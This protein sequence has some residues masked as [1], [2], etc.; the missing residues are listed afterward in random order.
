MI[1][2]LLVPLDGTELADSA[3]PCAVTLARALSARITLLHVLEQ[4]ASEMVHGQRHLTAADEAAAYLQ[5]VGK[6]LAAQ[7]LEV[8]CHVHTKAVTD[9]AEG[10]AAHQGELHP[11]LIV[12]C[13]HGPAGLARRMRGSLA[14]QVVGLGRTPLLLVRPD[15]VATDGEF[16][17]QRLLV[18]VDG[19]QEHGAGLELALDLAA[20]AQCRLHLLSVIPS[21]SSLAGNQATLSRFSPAASQKLQDLAD[22]NLRHYQAEAL[23][24]ATTRGVKASSEI[25]PGKISE[26]I[27][28]TATEQ[29][30]DLIVM[31][32][33]GKS[34]SRAFW[35]NSVA[36]GV[37]AKT[38]RPIL[39]VPVGAPED[40][41]P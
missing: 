18:P 29:Q 12:M 22:L 7:G 37:Q 26:V 20:A 38:N 2:H 39:L 27:V 32:T 28:E 24:R 15:A 21:L 30:A 10:I 36:V 23:E 11:D 4:D 31:A 34:G 14:Q 33:H 8:A 6:R 3:L 40:L 41:C 13:T 5:E 17:L 16:L 25:R 1:E 19:R 9:V 35:N